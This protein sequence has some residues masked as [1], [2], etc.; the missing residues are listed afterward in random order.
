MSLKKADLARQLGNKIAGQRK[1]ES[2]AQRF[3]GGGTSASDGRKPQRTNPLLEKLLSR[4]P[5][6]GR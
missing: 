5:K 4:A 6:S 3:A 1:N 2:A